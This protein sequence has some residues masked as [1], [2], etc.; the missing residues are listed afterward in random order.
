MSNFLVLCLKRI[1]TQ[2]NENQYKQF[3]KKVESTGETTYATLKK[4]VLEFLHEKNAFVILPFLG[5][6]YSLTIT[7]LVLLL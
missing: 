4:L 3:I 1:N 5:A 2:L 7:S 6:C